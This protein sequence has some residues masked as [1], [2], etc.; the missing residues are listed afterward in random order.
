MTE[1]IIDEDQKRLPRRAIL[2]AAAIGGA[3]TLFTGLGYAGSR[4]YDAITTLRQD[5]NQI[6]LEWINT[7]KEVPPDSE[8][9][10]F[11]GDPSA[12]SDP[13]RWKKIGV[14]TTSVKDFHDLQA[15]HPGS[16]PAFLFLDP[17]NTV[18]VGIASDGGNFFSYQPKNPDNYALGAKV[19]EQDLRDTFGLWL[20][21]IGSFVIAA[22]QG[23]P[24][25]TTVETIQEQYP[26]VKYV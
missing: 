15:Q 2:R 8:W 20:P 11:P 21:G 23:L 25:T 19:G 13:A 7:G 5:P 10:T 6:L 14:I 24:L 12:G 26:G 3:A 4:I 18:H 16:K 9:V 1:R 17:G 22:T